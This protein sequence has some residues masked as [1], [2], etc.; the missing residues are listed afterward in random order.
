MSHV[1]TI[2]ISVTNL[3]DLAEAAKRLG[4]ELCRGQTSFKWWGKWENDY[5]AADAAYRNGI[6][7]EDYG[8]CEHAIRFPHNQTELGYEIG[9]VRRT[10]GKPGYSLVWDFIDSGLS[11]RVGGQDAG[12]LKQAYALSAARRTAMAQGY[13]V[14]GEKKLPNGKIQLLLNK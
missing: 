11:R 3:D 4:G 5:D 14:S 12:L 6:K 7:P 10:D 2:S 1:A 8:K 9:V 13:R